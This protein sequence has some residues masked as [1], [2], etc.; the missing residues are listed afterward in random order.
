MNKSLVFELSVVDHRR[1]FFEP[2]ETALQEVASSFSGGFLAASY[3]T[4]TEYL[5]VLTSGLLR[6]PLVVVADNAART[7]SVREGIFSAVK[8][9][10]PRCSMILF[11][12]SMQSRDQMYELGVVDRIVDSASQ[13]AIARLCVVVKDAIRDFQQ[14]VDSFLIREFR[15]T[16]CHAPHADEC[17]VDDEEGALSPTRMLVE[18]ARG[19]ERGLSYLRDLH[20]INLGGTVAP[21]DVDDPV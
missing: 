19:T 16:V 10:A 7:P 1:E 13:D 21:H 12:A 6:A 2:V 17:S 4:A 9:L 11:S 14:T 8:D 20:P 15:K 3:P 18:M 5:S